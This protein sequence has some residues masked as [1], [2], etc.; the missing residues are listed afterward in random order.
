MTMAFHKNS[1]ALSSLLFLLGYCSTTAVA[2]GPTVSVENG[3]YEGVYS[4]T[5]DQDFFLGIPFA[6][7]PLGS[8]RFH[9]PVSLNT[10]WE[11]TKKATEYYPECVGYGVCSYILHIYYIYGEY[12]YMCMLDRLTMRRAMIG[13]IRCPRTVWLSMWFVLQGMRMRACLWQCGSMG[14]SM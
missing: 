9:Q 2:T 12:I 14:K 11:G 6:Q 3:T 13:L 7:P 8:L 1:L 4:S 10:S 5:Y